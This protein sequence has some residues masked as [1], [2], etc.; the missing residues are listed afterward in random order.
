MV[1]IPMS[2]ILP[3]AKQGNYA[4]AQF[5]I[6]GLLWIQAAYEIAEELNSPIILAASDRLIDYLGGFETIYQM[7]LTMHKR[8]NVS[9]P[10]ALH[11]DHGMSIENCIS[12]I[13]AGFSSVMYDGSHLPIL[14]NI[15]NTKKVCEYAQKYG[16][17]VEAEVGTVGGT[18]DGVTGGVSYADI[19]ECVALV[20]ETKVDA[21]AAALGSIHGK[22][23]GRPKLG[24]S[25]MEQLSNL[26]DIP[27]VLHGASGI[28][29][30]Q[31]KK[32]IELGHAKINFNTELVTAWA[33]SVRKTMQEN[34]NFYEPRL[35]MGPAKVSVKEKMHQIIHNIGSQNSGMTI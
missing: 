20:K 33:D 5:N 21:L 35:I 26:I 16:V 34:P 23:Q 31:L 15:E 4:V 3:Q 32:C 25:Q 2:K 29:M 18:E 22:Y 9:V 27:L 11:L 6:N 7:A 24:F 19:N 30:D 12:A 10:V 14:K 17:S 28:P 8:M 1:F 13:D